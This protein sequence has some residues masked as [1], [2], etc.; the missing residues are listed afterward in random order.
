[1]ERFRRSAFFFC[2][3]ISDYE[4]G[5]ER[6]VPNAHHRIPHGDRGCSSRY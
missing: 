1:M 3:E 5:G 4:G 2:G 6:P